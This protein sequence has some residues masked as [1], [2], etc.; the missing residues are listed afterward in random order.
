MASTYPLPPFLLSMQHGLIEG[1][2]P[3]SI[4]FRPSRQFYNVLLPNRAYSGTLENGLIKPLKRL[5]L[6][7]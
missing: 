2:L 7:N 5:Y 6:E 1:H 4:R 3:T